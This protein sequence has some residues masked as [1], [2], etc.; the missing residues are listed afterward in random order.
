MEESQKLTSYKSRLNYG[1]G[2]N[3][4]FPKC[5]CLICKREKEEQNEK[6]RPSNSRES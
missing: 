6:N 5:K 4:C 1:T 2:I 3:E